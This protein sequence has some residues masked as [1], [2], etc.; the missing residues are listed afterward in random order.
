MRAN[1]VFILI[2][3][4]FSPAFS[5]EKNTM[6][7]KELFKHISTQDSGFLLKKEVWQILEIVNIIDS[8]NKEYEE[9][10]REYITEKD[11]NDTIA[12]YYK[13]NN[14]NYIFAIQYDFWGYYYGSNILIEFFPKGEMVKNE[15]YYHCYY[16]SP[17]G[18]FN[19]LGDFF[20]LG[21]YHTCATGGYYNANLFLM[22]EI[23]SSDSLN[24]IPFWCY[25]AVTD[26]YDT[27]ENRDICWA[28]DGTIKKLENDSLI[29]TYSPRGEIWGEDYDKV[30]KTI[31]KEPFDILYI[32]ENNQWHVADKGNYEK[33]MWSTCFYFENEF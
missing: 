15:I 24:Q 8:V 25:T 12:K 20:S 19:K 31:N 32:Y 7:E 30:V 16:G 2:M 14:G 1:F 4:V 13:K 22:K 33:L 11:E 17:C 3:S 9:E 23:V 26:D 18:N 28:C 21:I 10:Y 29:I 6:S 27:I 5:Q